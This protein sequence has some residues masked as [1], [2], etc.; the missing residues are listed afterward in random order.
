MF[1]FIFSCVATSSSCRFSCFLYEMVNC[2]VN[3]V[4]FA[5]H[6]LIARRCCTCSTLFTRIESEKQRITQYYRTE[7]SE[8]A[9]RRNT[10]NRHGLTWHY[11]DVDVG[12]GELA[13]V[14]ARLSRC[15]SAGFWRL[16]SYLFN[17]VATN[18]KYH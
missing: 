18:E 16:S 14:R 2:V 17:F 11:V 15:C 1:Y 5:T 12:A 9:E 13:C 4:S 7:S 6:I 3:N 10:M 8:H